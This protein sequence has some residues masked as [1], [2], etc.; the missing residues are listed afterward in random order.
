MGGGVL[1]IMVE[2]LDWYFEHFDSEKA[3]RLGG[4]R[5]NDGILGRIGI[6][7]PDP[8]FWTARPIRSQP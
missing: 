4:C 2:E 3:A 6:L 8:L 5:P 7:G 1:F